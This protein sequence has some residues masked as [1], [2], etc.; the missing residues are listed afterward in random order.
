MPSTNHARCTLC[1]CHSQ[2][3]CHNAGRPLAE[4]DRAT[5]HTGGPAHQRRPVFTCR[6]D[7]AGNGRCSHCQHCE[8]CGEPLGTGQLLVVNGRKHRLCT[9]SR[10]CDGTACDHGTGCRIMIPGCALT[11]T[12]DPLL[13]TL[14]ERGLAGLPSQSQHKEPEEEPPCPL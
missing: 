4:G 5:G 13:D 6:L 3:R 11:P 8:L 9:D 14:L 12:G 1:G 7:P 10:P 2:R